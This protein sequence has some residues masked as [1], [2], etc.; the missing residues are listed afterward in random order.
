[1]KNLSSKLTRMRLDLEEY[2]FE[3]EYIKGKENVAA[4]ALSWVTISELNNMTIKSTQILA[5]IRSMTKN[6]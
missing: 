4:D 2:D 3:V 5:V 1:M 6:I